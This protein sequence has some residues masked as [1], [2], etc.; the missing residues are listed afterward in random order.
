MAT[1]EPNNNRAQTAQNDPYVPELLTV[2]PPPHIKAPVRTRHIMLDVIIA[3]IPALVWGVYLF[4]LRA[5]AIVL[6]SVASCLVCELVW[7]L[8]MKKPV[9]LGDLS[10]A[11]TG[12][13]LGL[14]LPVGVP[15]WMPVVGSVFAIIIVKQ[16]FGG[17]GKNIMNP[18]LAAR[19]FMMISWPD[20]MNSYSEPFKAPGVFD[21]SVDVTAGATPL[22][23]LKTGDIP[24][25][26]MVDLL[27]G[28]TAGAIG[29]VSALLLI[30]GGLYLMIRRVISW[31]IPVA[32]IGT[33]AA[34]GFIL[35]QTENAVDFMLA[36]ILSGGVML[37]AIFMATDYT[38]SPITEQGKLVFGLG[39]GLITMLIR[40]YGAYPGGVSFA[41][42]IMNTLVWYIDRFTRPVRFGGVTRN[43]K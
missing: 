36:S 19:V 24:D 5:L 25:V 28:N 23:A 38:T 12:L 30:A 3:L 31:H 21:K 42:L 32:Y 16:L 27:L 35:P 40:M 41:I 4:G 39:C 22:A 13:L 1:G 20:L 33:V 10:A 7:Q 43:G 9:M 37:G 18:A 29:E 8:L 26:P 11:V 6:I 14:N 15:L 17:I 34:I 2:S